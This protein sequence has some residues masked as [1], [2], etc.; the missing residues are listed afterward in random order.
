MYKL[1]YYVIS[2]G[3]I[4]FGPANKDLAEDY[5]YQE[6]KKAIYNQLFEWGYDHPDECSGEQLKKAAWALGASGSLFEVVN[7]NECEELSIT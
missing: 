7:E 6:R 2:E 1:K 3:N 4:I 5:A